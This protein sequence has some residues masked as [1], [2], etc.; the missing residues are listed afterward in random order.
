MVTVEFWG[1]LVRPTK[2]LTLVKM[3]GMPLA[4]VLNM[5][6]HSRCQEHEDGEGLQLRPP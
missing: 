5:R 6:V 3:Q 1:D 4:H 2:D